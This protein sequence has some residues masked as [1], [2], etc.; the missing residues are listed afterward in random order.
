MK[1]VKK[2]QSAIFAIEELLP[3]HVELHVPAS[4]GGRSIAEWMAHM[5][6]LEGRV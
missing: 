6:N 2:A 3:A 5:K 4:F 1:M